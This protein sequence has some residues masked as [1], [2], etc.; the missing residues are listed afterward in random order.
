M[1]VDLEMLA[2]ALAGVALIEGHHQA[3][4]HQQVEGCVEV[5]CLHHDF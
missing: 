3:G 1:R 4:G 2:A 5:R